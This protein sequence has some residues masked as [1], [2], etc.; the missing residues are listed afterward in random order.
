MKGWTKRRVA[1]ILAL[2]L[3]ASQMSGCKDNGTA[4]QNAASVSNNNAA[5]TEETQAP[6]EETVSEDAEGWLEENLDNIR[7][8]LLEGDYAQVIDILLGMQDELVNDPDFN[9]LLYIAYM[10][11]GNENDAAAL[12]DNPNLDAGAFTDSFLENAEALEGNEDIAAMKRKLMEH[13]LALGESAPDA[14]AAVARIGANISN[15]DPSD[16]TAYAARYIAAL[17]VGDEA[18]MEAI[19]EEAKAN[20]VTAE[21]LCT[22]TAEYIERVNLTTISVEE[23]EEGIK[24]STTYNA[25]GNVVKSEVIVDNQ[26][27]TYTKFVKNSDGN[28]VGE[29]L[30]DKETGEPIT[31]TFYVFERVVDPATGEVTETD[32]GAKEVYDY[33]DGVIDTITTYMADGAMNYQVQ[34]NGQG[35]IVKAYDYSSGEKKEFSGDKLDVLNFEVVDGDLISITVPTVDENGILVGKTETTYDYQNP[36][37]LVTEWSNYVGS[38]KVSE[39]IM[40]YTFEDEAKADRKSIQSTKYTGEEKEKIILLY[41]DNICTTQSTILSLNMYGT[42]IDYY[43]AKI[44]YKNHTWAE[45]DLF[46]LVTGTTCTNYYVMD[47]SNKY[48]LTKETYNEAGVLTERVFSYYTGTKE[49]SALTVRYDEQGRVTA[50]VYYGEDR[51]VDIKKPKTEV[52]YTYEDGKKIVKTV[53]YD[54]EGNKVSHSKHEYNFTYDL[55]GKTTGIT[56]YMYENDAFVTM[57]S[58][59]YLYDETGRCYYEEV[60]E[61]DV[62]TYE[63]VGYTN[64]DFYDGDTKLGTKH[65]TYDAA[66]DNWVQTRQDQYSYNEDG[67]VSKIDVYSVENGNGTKS[68]EINYT[69]NEDGSKKIEAKDLVTGKSSVTEYTYTENGDALSESIYEVDAENNRVDVSVKDYTYGEDGTLSGYTITA[70]DADGN[71]KVTHYTPEGYPYEIAVYDAEGQLLMVMKLDPE[72][73]PEETV[74]EETVPEETVPEETVAE[75]TVPEETIPEETV[76]EETIPEESIPEESIPE[77]SIPEESIPEESTSEETVPEETVPEETTAETTAE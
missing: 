51:V 31:R 26:D 33:K 5:V 61:I 62:N 14:Y 2:A 30:F 9:A 77:E 8:S 18:A 43:G 59:S 25:Q 72:T 20:G 32:T 49:T 58:T 35:D 44:D 12:L 16:P 74:P 4:A 41:E 36:V 1:L 68:H 17:A 67:T 75:E 60:L 42:Y 65:Y 11:N 6:T 52:Q 64:W 28:I 57:K 27:G 15:N 56:E 71:I 10:G 63:M 76:P 23:A 21:E 70:L 46:G 29:A 73:V 69:Y 55:D 24:T 66:T 47:T 7:Q 13:M 19:L 37:G 54:V 48:P 38:T 53:E 34:I 3:I 40:E 39:M 45:Q 50:E 22:T